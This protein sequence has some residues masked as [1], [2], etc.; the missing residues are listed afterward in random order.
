MSTNFKTAAKKKRS[1]VD[2]IWTMRTVRRI[3]N[4]AFLTIIALLMAFPFIWMVS[5]TFKTP[6]YIFSL[7]P[8]LIPDKLGQPDMFSSLRK[9]L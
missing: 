1:S 9:P 5:T 2:T 6:S 3:L 8:Q 4:Y 7:P